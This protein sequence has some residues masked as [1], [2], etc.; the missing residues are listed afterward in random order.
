MVFYSFKMCSTYVLNQYLRVI[1]Y[2]FYSNFRAKRMMC[3]F[4]VSSHD[5]EYKVYFMV[6][7]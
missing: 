3:I 5:I 4:C 7:F 2:N 1:L 6:G